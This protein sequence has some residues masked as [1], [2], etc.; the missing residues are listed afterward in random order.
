MA[1]V[2]HVGKPGIDLQSCRILCL[3]LPEDM[4]STGVVHELDGVANPVDPARLV[5]VGHALWTAWTEVPSHGLPEL[6]L[7][8]DSGGIAPSIALALASGL[9]YHLAWRLDIVPGPRRAEVFT[10]GRLS[11]KRVLV[12]DDTVTGGG[13]V[14]SLISALR[15]ESAD[16]VG[17]VCLAEDAAGVGRRH[18]ESTGVPL[19]SLSTL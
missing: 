13:L 7:G 3:D 14:T 2:D 15:E 16:V 17:A 1:I 6:L 8:V 19:V 18:V 11:G 5:A 9:P 4:P 12:V 10:N